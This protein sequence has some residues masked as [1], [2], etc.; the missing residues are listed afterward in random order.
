MRPALNRAIFAQRVWDSGALT[1]LATLVHVFDD[2]GDYE[3]FVRRGEAI[4]HRATLAVG[5]D[6]A[7]RQLDLDLATLEGDDTR[8]GCEGG[9]GYAISEP[10]LVSFHVSR[11]TGAYSVRVQRRTER[12]K[13][14][15]LDS[16]ETIPEG[17]LFAV[18][19]VRP[20]AYTVADKVSGAEARI[21]VELPRGER[22]RMDKPAMIELQ[23]G[24]EPS[25]LHVLA[26][27][28]VV[29]R[30][31]NRARIGIELTDEKA[32]VST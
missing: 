22:Y 9:D 2:A 10:G 21:S 32:T 13:E 4:V 26:G 27:R 30:C 3:I 19:L 17:D 11:G 18:V 25:E 12:H 14:W 23:K 20:G 31:H 16:A 15:V 8:C 6:G 5:R 1:V 28:A 7:P 29:F 24:F